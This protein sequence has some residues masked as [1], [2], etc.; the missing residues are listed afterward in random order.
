MRRSPV[1]H[2]SA[3]SGQY[4]SLLIFLLDSACKFTR[5]LN[6]EHRSKLLSSE[7]HLEMYIDPTDLGFIDAEF[8]NCSVEGMIEKCLAYKV[9]LREEIKTSDWSVQTLSDDQI[10]YAC[11]EVNCV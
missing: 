2:F 11:V 8:D 9:D 6:K 7:H 10:L 3:F 5:F 4:I 1:P